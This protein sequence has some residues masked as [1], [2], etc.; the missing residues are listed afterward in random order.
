MNDDEDVV[1]QHRYYI[2]SAGAKCSFFI[3]NKVI[4]LN[5]YGCYYPDDD[6]YGFYLE[7]EYI[8]TGTYRDWEAEMVE[9]FKYE[10]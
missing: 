2:N 4:H 10:I 5:L 7:A 9:M 1:G 6:K 8:R 3:R